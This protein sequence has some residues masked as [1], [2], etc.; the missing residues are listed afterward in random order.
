MHYRLTGPVNESNSEE[1]LEM[2]GWS[3][4]MLIQQ[5][6][7]GAAPVSDDECA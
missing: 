1:V 5:F 6:I 4:E 3:W 7:A 2:V